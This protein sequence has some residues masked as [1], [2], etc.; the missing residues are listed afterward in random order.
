MSDDSFPEEPVLLDD[1]DEPEFLYSAS[2]R[3]H[4]QDMDF[5]EISERLALSPTSTHRKGEKRGP[6]SPAY[7]DDAWFYQSQIDPV[8]P[9]EEHILALWDV[10]KAHTDYLKSLK[11]RYKVD[12]FCGYRSNCQTAGI[13]VDYRCL[14]LFT[15]LEIPFD[16]SIIVL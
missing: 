3:I 1:E 12:V 11:R 2:L 15:T 10:L 8:R 7:R 4:G 6:R 16:L 14:E 13:E 5:N 9:L